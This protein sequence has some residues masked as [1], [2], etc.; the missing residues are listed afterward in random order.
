MMRWRF[1]AS[2]PLFRLDERLL[3][4]VMAILVGICSGLAA[5]ALS[6]SLEAL[7]GFLRQYRHLWWALFLPGAGAALSSL[8]LNKIP[9]SA[10]FPVPGR[11][12][13]R[14]IRARA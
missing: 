6:R 8:F 10:P 11:A 4:M 5:L 12:D 13:S 7:L 3:V 14:Q 2:W 9:F 1:P